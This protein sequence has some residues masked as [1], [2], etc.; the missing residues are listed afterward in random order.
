[1]IPVQGTDPAKEALNTIDAGVPTSSVVPL[2]ANTSATS[3]LVEWNGTDDTGGSGVANYDVFV[4]DNGGPFETLVA[5]TTDTS[6]MFDG[7]N[8][9]TYGFYSMATDNVGHVEATPPEPDA[10]TTIV[11]GP[12]WQN[13]ANPRDTNDDGVVAPLDALLII[14]YLN[15]QGAGPL[16][17]P[18]VPPDVPPPFYDVNGDDLISPFDALLIINF[19]NSR[20]SGEGETQNVVS[21]ETAIIPAIP[22]IANSII[23]PSTERLDHV[24]VSPKEPFLFPDVLTGFPLSESLQEGLLWAEEDTEWTHEDLEELL[25]ELTG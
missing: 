15:R 2:A 7:E 8:G 25:A 6:V 12:P 4:S 17:V 9:H 1:M 16:P 22:L 24:K 21:P 5:G 23:A 19:L 20:G 10:E 18:L 11:E 3:F 14:N 13:D